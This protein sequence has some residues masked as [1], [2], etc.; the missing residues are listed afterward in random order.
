MNTV[1]KIEDHEI[2]IGPNGGQFYKGRQ[3]IDVKE[4]PDGSFE[5]YYC[6]KDRK[7]LPDSP[8]IICGPLPLME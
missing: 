7:P 4:L 3:I 6:D 1:I 8:K 5:M 2:V